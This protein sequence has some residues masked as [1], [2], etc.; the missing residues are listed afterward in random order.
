MVLR[1]GEGDDSTQATFNYMGYQGGHSHADQLGLVLYGLGMPLAPDAGSVKYRLLEQEGWFKQTLAHNTMVV[2]GVSQERA[3]AGQVN[4]F[5]GAN[6]AQA[7]MAS[8]AN[9]DLYPGVGLTRT[10]MLND[11]YLIDIFSADSADAHTYDWV[12]HNVGDFSTSDLDFQPVDAPLGETG[13]YE[14][15]TDVQTAVSDEN[16]QGEWAITSNTGVKINVLGE[17]ATTYFTADGPI[18]ARVGDEIADS[19]VPLLMARREMT[20]TQFV[21]IL[22]PYQD[23]TELLEIT[24][25][26]ITDENDQP[27]PA[28]TV[29]AYQIERDGGTDLFI[30][31]DKL[32]TKNTENIDL[33]ATWAWLSQLDGEF[34]WLMM[35]GALAAG[36]GWTISQ[37]DLDIDKTPEGMGLYVEVTDSG[38]LIVN[39]IHQ[40]V[41]HITL[42]GF[43]DSAATIVEYNYDGEEIREMPF[44]TNEGGVIKF[45]AHPGVSYEVISE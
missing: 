22:Q 23:D 37:E 38:N 36:D 2:D 34:Q 16:W 10:L 9:P 17:P 26:T 21:S 4:Q 11:D 7:Q 35:N 39:N 6:G 27:I 30:L 25:V 41:T 1:S 13:G 43:M 19:D 24:A 45:L 33:N 20:G 42:E 32:S 5:V 8:V 44:K 31:G 28:E 29:H 15:L 18:A 14:Y 3:D 40:F 12:Y